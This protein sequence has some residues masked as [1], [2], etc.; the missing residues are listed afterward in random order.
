MSTASINDLEFLKPT[1]ALGDGVFA[2]IALHPM[3]KADAQGNYPLLGKIG[4]APPP[5]ITLQFARDATVIDTRQWQDVIC[6]SDSVALADGTTLGGD[7][8]HAL[9][10]EG[11]DI[12]MQYG[13]I[14]GTMV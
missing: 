10:C 9:D 4:E 6:H 3:P 2:R 5:T 11:W 12:L 13:L 8:L 1:I 7:A 14:P